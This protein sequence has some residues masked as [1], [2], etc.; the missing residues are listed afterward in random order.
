[1]ASY[2]QDGQPLAI[3]TPLGKDKLLLESLSGEEALGELFVFRLT[4]LSVDEQIDD[5][6]LVGQQVSFRVNRGDG[7]PRWF[8]GYVSRFSWAGRDDVLTRWQLEVVPGLWFA[9]LTSDCKIFQEKAVPDI[10]SAVLGDC[11]Q[12]SLTKKVSGSHSPWEYCV[13]FRETD[14]A[15]V[16]RLMEFEGMAYHFEH[17]EKSL[18]MVVSDSNSAFT[19]CGDAEV[20]AV[21][22]FS[23]PD[24]PGQLIEWQHE[25]AYKP[26]KYAQTDY[27]FE[28]P[29]TDLLVTSNG[30]SP[31]AGAAAAELFDFPGDYSKKSDGESLGKFRIEAEEVGASTA[32]GVSTCRTFSPGYTFK[33]SSHPNPSEKG[34]KYLLTRVTHK[35]GNRGAYE[36]SAVVAE[37]FQYE[38]SFECIP[39]DT[40]WRTPRKTPWPAG[41]V[42]TALVVGP[43]GEEIYTDEYG[44][45][46]VQFPWD[47]YGKKNEQSSCW[48]RVAQSL[49]G[50]QFGAQWLP[51]IGMEVVVS[52]LDGDPNRPLVTGV[53][54]NGTNKPPFELPSKAAQSGW[55][56]RSTKDGQTANA[57]QFIFD[58]TK[59]S[60]LVTLHAEKDFA[61]TVEND[62]TVT[63]GF[64]T[65]KNG[66]R[67]VKVF[68]NVTE[69]VGA[70]GCNDGS[71]SLTVYKNNKTTVSTGNETCTVE[72]GDAA[73]EVSKGKH[74]VDVG[75]SQA[76]TVG[77]GHT[78]TVKSGSHTVDVKSGSGTMKATAW[79][80]QG[81]ESITLK[82]G[83][84]SIAISASG[85][86]INGMTVSVKGQTSATLEG[87]QTTVK[88]SATLQAKGAITMIG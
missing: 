11:S 76:I 13:Q 31:Y 5:K 78:L 85:I 59:G 12:V 50:P 51:R 9:G 80:I 88:A 43:S 53:V 61:R 6:K 27:N 49:A 41:T 21:Q 64:D 77:N 86:T 67:T 38:N 18:K 22:Q 32:K 23:S 52:H 82:V 3:E 29:S 26:G 17:A 42:Q 79:T 56:T 58:D 45:I 75:S 44:R 70:S 8:T 10:V 47:R 14:L 36:T 66:D 28:Q 87:L 24:Q 4:C 60:E 46:K 74:T 2:T 54:Y 7:S 84:N 48:I 65:K 34:K 83:S 57:N 20:S 73:L 39:A 72:Q 1:M 55:Q 40:V 25:Y 68:N 81:M 63:V 16:S 69:E 15:F 62:D 30:K 33:I 35:A 19:D 37:A 71:R